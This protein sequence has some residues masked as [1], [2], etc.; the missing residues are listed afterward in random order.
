LDQSSD[1]WLHYIGN[2]TYV[3]FL[4]ALKA[5]S[6][7]IMKQLDAIDKGSVPPR[8][9]N[10]IKW[11][12]TCVDWK[13]EAPPPS[14]CYENCFYDGCYRPDFTIQAYCDEE[15]GVCSHGMIDEKCEGVPPFG[16]YDGMEKTFEGSDM[17]AV[18]WQDD[19]LG[20]VR[21]ADCPAPDLTGVK[22]SAAAMLVKEK[23][24]SLLAVTIVF[25]LFVS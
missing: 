18:C 16:S 25:F 10:D 3:P 2:N 6:A 19:F 23:F 11:W 5:R 20:P 9:L 12:E 17:P 1:Q 14:S 15:R 22:T 7:E 8:D 13:S 21:V 4:P 24:L